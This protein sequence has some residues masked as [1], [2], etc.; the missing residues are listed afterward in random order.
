[1]KPDLFWIAGPWRGRLAIA[2]RPRGGDWLEDEIGS[3]RRAGI[4]V[5]VSLLESNEEDQLDLVDEQRAAEANSIRFISFPIPDRGVPVSV[6]EAMSLMTSVASLLDEGNNVAVHCRQGIGRSGLIA[7]GILAT[8]GVNPEE[9]IEIVSAAR[10]LAIP[11]TPEQCQWVVQG[12]RL[13]TAGCNSLS[14]AANAYAS[15]VLCA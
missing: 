7:A 14:P 13:K 4:D 6:P 1:V 11:E 8:S 15:T 3:W 10:G 2:T 12:L 5:V 9:A